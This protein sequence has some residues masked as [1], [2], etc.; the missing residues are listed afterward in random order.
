MRCIRRWSWTTT[1]WASSNIYAYTWLKNNMKKWLGEQDV[2]DALAQAATDNVTTE[3]GLALLD[4]A[5]V[6]RQYPAVVD[7]FGHASDE[8]FF[9][10][11]AGLEG[12]AAVSEA[13]RHVPGEIWRALPGRNRYFSHTLG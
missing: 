7:Y 13:M 9:D 12:G 2:T 11:L 8:T 10:D 1:A 6:V 5:D 3:M 4:V